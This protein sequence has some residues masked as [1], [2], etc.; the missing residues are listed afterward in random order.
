[1]QSLVYHANKRDGIRKD[2]PDL[3]E[4]TRI[5]EVL[6]KRW[7]KAVWSVPEDFL[8]YAH[9]ERCVMDLDWNSSPGYP[10]LFQATTNRILFEVEDGKPSRRALQ[11]MWEVV[12]RQINGRQ[13]DPIRLFVKPECHKQ[14]KLDNMAYR[15]ISSVSVVD[16]IV[17]AMLFGDMNTN[18][19]QNY[20]EVPAK[21]GWSPHG[22]G[23]RIMPPTGM[24][25]L[26]KSAWDWSVNA[27]IV[28]TILELR[29]RLCRNDDGRW[30]SLACWRYKM[31]F[32]EPVFVTSGGLLLKQRNP[33]VMKSGCF[34]TIIDNS[35]GQDILHVRVCRELGIEVG[36]LMSMGDDTTQR[37][38]DRIDDYCERLSQFCHLK[39]KAYSTE[40]AGHRF[41]M[42]SIEPLYKGKHAY[43][44]L[45]MN[46]KY[47]DEMAASYALLY[48]RSVFR[49][50]LR[51]MMTRAGLE[52]PSLDILD[53][54]YDS[55]V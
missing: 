22:G 36:D 1:M 47:A 24:V 41:G 26:D 7:E 31:L 6:A 39:S 13:S 54:I 53:V 12:T 8:T 21:V 51:S 25:S 44:L 2:G 45:H 23:W 40:F 4:R 14:K 34:N 42:C 29:S 30:Y 17:D 55:E 18:C 37:R 43:N 20:L 16:Q 52:I 46:D 28:E 3:Y 32:G 48:H 15:L 5:M 35:I 10:Y 19:M 27:W 38:F 50:S 9:Y 49:D 11:R 33:G